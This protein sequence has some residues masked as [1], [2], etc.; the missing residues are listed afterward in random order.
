MKMTFHESIQAFHT[1]FQDKKQGTNLPCNKKMLIDRRICKV[2][3]L[4]PLRR[5]IYLCE[6]AFLK[7]L[8]E[9]W[10]NLSHVAS[11]EGITNL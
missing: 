8:I 2:Q 1:V 3:K 6:K 9:L 7:C 4:T 5:K 11:F 10:Q